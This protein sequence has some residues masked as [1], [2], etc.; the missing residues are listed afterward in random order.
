MTDGYEAIAGDQH[1][2]VDGGHLR[3]VHQGPD[4]RLQVDAEPVA[5]DANVQGGRGEHLRQPGAQQKQVVDHRH[6]LYTGY[7]H[8][9][10]ILHTY[11]LLLD[12]I[13]SCESTMRI[14]DVNNLLMKKSAQMRRKHCKH[15]K[16]ESKIFAP[17]QTPFP[18]ARDVQNLISY[19][20]SLPSPTDPV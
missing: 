13:F 19:R 10:I 14:V 11:M 20:W 9:H 15:C 1:G 17:P 8:T 12:V 2:H 4:E 7:E 5:G 18:G 16:A 3:D 6:Y